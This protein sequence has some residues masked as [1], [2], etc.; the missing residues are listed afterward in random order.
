MNSCLVHFRL[1]GTEHH[2]DVKTHELLVDVIR[3]RLGLTGTKQSCGLGIC[4]ACTVLLD[5][6]AVSSCCLFAFEIDGKDV[7]TIEG[8]SSDGALHPLQAAFIQHGGF[9]CG[10]CTPGMILTAK[11]LLDV[12][13]NPTSGEI[14]EYMNGNVCRCTGY[15]MIVESIIA[16]SQPRKVPSR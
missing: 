14:K 10:F 8:L 9:Q 5:G 6:Q 7:L 3:D 4:G 12:Q 13:A 11:A 16:A 15:Q 1:N 2:L